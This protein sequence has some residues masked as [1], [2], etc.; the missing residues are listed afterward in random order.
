MIGCLFIDDA[1][2]D[3]V[4]GIKRSWPP[5]YRR[6]SSRALRRPKSLAALPRARNSRC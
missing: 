6:P 3:R 2:A 4:P 1:I 5:W